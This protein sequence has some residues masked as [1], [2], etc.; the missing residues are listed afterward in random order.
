MRKLTYL[1]AVSQDGFV[2]RPDGSISDFGF[3]GEH[4][5][6]VL[7]LYPET[8]PTHLREH[9][10]VANENLQFDAVLMGRATY[11]L[12]AQ[13]G[14]TNPYQHL[15]QYL[16]SSTLT[17]SPDKNVRLIRND[18]VDFVRNLKQQD[19][20]GIWLCG[21]PKLAT[22]LLAEIDALTLKINPF[23]M[24]SGKPLFTDAFSKRNLELLKRKDYEN[25]FS[26]VQYK[27]KH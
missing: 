16:F 11:D 27:V 13:A 4:V 21:G 9:F 7:K 15:D 14:F 23:L 6:D 1:I 5:S 18:A 24:G 22:K 8:I 17:E 19:G 12:G 10:P 2:C 25:G 20:L 26:L 3:E